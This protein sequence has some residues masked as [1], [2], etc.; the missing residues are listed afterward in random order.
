MTWIAPDVERPDGPLV[1]P[2]RVLLQAMLDWYR[3]T[4]L[5]KCAG[6]TGEQLA[7]HAV[8]PSGLSLLGL[9]RHMTKVERLWFRIRFAGEPAELLYGGDEDF[10]G[11]DPSRAAADYARFTEEWKHADAAVANTSLDDTF[12]D[13]GEPVS[14]RMLYLRMVQEYA[15]H[16]GHADLLRERIDGQTGL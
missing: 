14:L 11:A 4:L 2:E 7:S 13:D 8:E 6:L 3:A 12:V 16:C 10:A 9:I 15:R 1:A 5:H